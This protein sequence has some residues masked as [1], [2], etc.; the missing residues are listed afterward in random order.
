MK[1]KFA[2]KVLALALTGALAVCG[3][4]AVVTVAAVAPTD[5]GIVKQAQAKVK[6]QKKTVFRG[7]EGKWTIYGLTKAQKK[8]VKFKSSKKSVATVSKKGIVK[9]K[10]A[11]KTTLTA[12][13]KGKTILKYKFTVKEAK[14]F[15]GTWRLSHGSVSGTSFT[16]SDVASGLI[17]G[18]A[19]FKAG[20][21]M[22]LSLTANNGVDAPVTESASGK[23][24]PTSDT[25]A[26]IDSETSAS[27]YNGVLSISSK[28]GY[29]YFTK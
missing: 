4:F 13:L 15:V 14:Q 29:L 25:Y 3:A 12:K 23:W 27:V 18:T 8:K 21:K 22:S 17:T 19:V 16:E 10:K 20:G 9:A 6:T 7:W 24:I 28:D 5:T 1:G 11:G 26:K 2:G